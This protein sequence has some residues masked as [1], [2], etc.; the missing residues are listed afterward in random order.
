MG[1]SLRVQVGAV[2]YDREG[3]A[4]HA[5]NLVANVRK[6]LRGSLEGLGVVS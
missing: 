2:S 3:V 5:K 4:N 6:N 1:P